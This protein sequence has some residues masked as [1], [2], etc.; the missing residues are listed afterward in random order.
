LWYSHGSTISFLVDIKL[1]NNFLYWLINY[2]SL[3]IFV[4]IKFVK[5]YKFFKH[6]NKEFI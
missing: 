4:N 2:P 6:Y 3:N 5:G 1:Y